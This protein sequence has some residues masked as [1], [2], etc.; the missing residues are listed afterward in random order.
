MKYS[1]GAHTYIG[2]INIS[3]PHDMLRCCELYT[4]NNDDVTS[5]FKIGRYC[6]IAKDVKFLL[7]GYHPIDCI[8]T[9]PFFK[10][11]QGSHCNNIKRDDLIIGN[12]VYIG[13]GSRILSGITIGDGAVIGAYS[14][15]TKDVEPYTVVGGNPAKFIKKR[16]SDDVIKELIDI[17]WWN[18]DEPIIRTI[19]PL[20]TDRENPIESLKKVQ[21]IL[22]LHKQ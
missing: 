16:F 17:K 10:D 7:G 11:I 12:D 4:W 5:N 20:L 1:I 13:I 19:Y 15:V 3:D 6:S 2:D 21:E 8:S 22:T 14:V 9:Y 18:Y